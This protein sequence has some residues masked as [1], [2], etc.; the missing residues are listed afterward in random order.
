MKNLNRFYLAIVMMLSFFINQSCSEENV[1]PKTPTLDAP[2]SV[3]SVQ[4]GDKVDVSFSF[5]T[6]AKFKSAT[7]TATGGTAVVKIPPSTG[8]LEGSI[9]VEFTAGTSIGA[10]SIVLTLTDQQDQQ[11]TATAVVN[12]TNRIPIALQG[13]LVTQTLDANKIYLLKGIVFVPNGATLTIPAGTLIL[14]EKASKATL[15][16]QPGGK[17][18][19]NG[20][21]SQPI[22]FTSAQNVGERDRGDWGGLV[23]LG[24]AFVNQTAKPAIEGITP[25]QNYGS[26]AADGATPA[27]N[28]S[29]NSGV[30]TYVRVEYAGIE[31]TPNN[32]T[33][34][35]TL[36]ALG[37]G[38]TIDYVQA[39]FGGDD[40]FE[41]F[42]GT[43]NAKHLVSFSTWDD[44]FDTDFGW[45][46]NVQFGL[47][48]RNPFFADQSG[49]NAFE[50]DNQ[51][52]GNA[53]A[54]ICDG[55]TQAGC[56]RG[57]F[58]NIT[59][60]G[61]RDTQT[62]TISS[63]Y[64]NAIHLRRRT[65]ISIFN[66][67][68]SGFRIGLRLDDQGTLDNLTAGAGKHAY[69][70][71]TVP[72]TNLIGNST[73][74]ADAAFAT[75]LSSGD[76]TAISNYW[77]NNNNAVVNNFSATSNAT[78]FTDA[79]ITSTLF[80]GGQTVVTYPSDPNFVLLSGVV[81]ANNLNT[82]ANYTDAK[83]GA[84]FDKTGTFRGAFGA[85]DWTNGW[86]EFQ[87]INKTY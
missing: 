31:L 73:S 38:T 42:G 11:T 29:D 82:G 18:I 7:V 77:T 70:L 25:S 26:I 51:S 36:G 64:Q 34:S 1:I 22:V 66:S 13:T 61:P 37:N 3:T 62:R 23:I 4:L 8:S 41:W 52:N 74:I 19:A 28:A 69:N 72:G 5:V 43:V 56:T 40:G 17:L 65:S 45:G 12:I 60:L 86:S 44:D 53:I 50:S 49:S 24:N 84:F 32:E 33:N 21:A 30:L 75:G 78:F 87:P 14:G 35:I 80:W 6:L 54:G 81:D 27:T 47:I 58:S 15:V 10:G 46:G 71:I 63:N 39:S 16:V 83:L 68:F 76:A 55:T 2:S 59:V 79:G 9:V 85:A 67:F 48:V 57:V 20:T